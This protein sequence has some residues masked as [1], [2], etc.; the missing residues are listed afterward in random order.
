MTWHSEV[1]KTR[2]A[3]EHRQ[4][5][6]R[7]RAAKLLSRLI[8]GGHSDE[9]QTLLD[10][11]VANTHR[12]PRQIDEGPTAEL[13]YQVAHGRGDPIMRLYAKGY[14]NDQDLR[15]VREI[16]TILQHIAGGLGVRAQD[17][18]R[19]RGTPAPTD[20]W[21]SL[22]HARVYLPWTDR[23]RDAL[24]LI[25]G[26]IADGDSL[27]A[28]CRRHRVGWRKAVALVKNALCQYARMRHRYSDDQMVADR[29]LRPGADLRKAAA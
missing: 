14:L 17:L 15:S 1:E 4:P 27:G 19:T 10:M 8:R 18:N 13:L 25:I 22:L 16:G 9:A 12:R 20:G 2:L 21:L 29:Q 24:P 26:M 23:N 5:D 6:A 3:F 7:D 28:L 11:M